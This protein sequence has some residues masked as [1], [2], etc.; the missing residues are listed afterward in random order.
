[1][2]LEETTPQE[3][4]E[5][6]EAPEAKAV[7]ATDEAAGAKEPSAEGAAEEKGAGETQAGGPGRGG[8]PTAGARPERA[9][10][11]KKRRKICA[12][13][14]DKQSVIDYKDVPRLRRFLTERGKIVP[15][16]QSGTCAKHQR[17]LAMAIKRARECALLPYIVR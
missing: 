15:R 13:C 2:A 16:R 14:V 1:M 8:R 10:R 3:T 4:P 17:R 6:T 11:F 12:F 7:P 5:H 9:R